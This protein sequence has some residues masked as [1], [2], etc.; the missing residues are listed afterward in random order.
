MEYVP[1]SVSSDDDD[2]SKA[3]AL[4]DRR[5]KL[6]TAE[7]RLTSLY[8]YSDDAMDEHEQT[9]IVQ[10]QR[11]LDEISEIDSALAELHPEGSAF[12]TSDYRFLDEASYFILVQQLLNSPY[13]D[14]EHFI[15]NIDPTIAK[16][17]IRSVLSVVDVDDGK[18][19][20]MIFQNGL[21]LNFIYE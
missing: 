16:S 20:R 1:A 21:S 3:E 5:R 17:F 11:I 13:V 9:Y 7:K 4:H 12:D 14:Y 10:K 2:P 15:R 18:I 6:E 8:L 19:I